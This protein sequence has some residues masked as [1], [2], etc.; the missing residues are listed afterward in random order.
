MDTVIE[1]WF[2]DPSKIGATLVLMGLIYV[3]IKG[4]L[5]TSGHLDQVVSAHSAR[6]TELGTVYDKRIAELT[7][8]RDDYKDMLRDAVMLTKRTLETKGVIDEGARRAT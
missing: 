4:Q 3:L 1:Q 2:A 5:V 8:D 7:K 6:I